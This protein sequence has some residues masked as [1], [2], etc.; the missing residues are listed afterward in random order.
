MS[1]AMRGEQMATRLAVTQAMADELN[2]YLMRNDLYH[3]MLVE[4]PA[5][6]EQVVM[7]LGAL[8]ENLAPLG[9]SEPPLSDAQRAQLAAIRDGVAR[10]RRTLPDQWQAL[11]HRELKAL[12]DSR[13]WY[14]DDLEQRRAEPDQNGPE[15]Q[16]RARID[17]IL[18]ELGGAAGLAEER[19]RLAELD[20]R[21]RGKL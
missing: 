18:R 2:D 19:R 12:L 16:Q 21:E 9:N 20:A 15:A 8:L 6:S 10:S 13:K 1:G 17:L 7:T 5:G 14:L 11:L 4:T 3:Q